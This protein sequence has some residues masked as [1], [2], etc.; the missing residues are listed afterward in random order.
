MIPVPFAACSLL[1]GSRQGAR[2][3]GISG[4]PS[5]YVVF[6]E[7]ELVRTQRIDRPLLARLGAI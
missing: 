4:L 1:G 6:T 7:R 5:R 2:N 3:L